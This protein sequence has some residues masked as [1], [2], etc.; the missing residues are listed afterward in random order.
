M[1]AVLLFLFFACANASLLSQQNFEIKKFS[2]AKDVS[3]QVD[4]QYFLHVPENKELA[5][6]ELLPL[7][8]FLHGAGERGSDADLLTVHGPPKLIKAGEDMPFIVIAP[9]CPANQR[10]DAQSLQLF[11]ESMVAQL[12]VDQSRIYL[13]GL[14]M[15]GFGTWD[16]SIAN[17]DYYA[18][19]APICGGSDTNAWDAPRAIKDLPT[20]AFHG[21]MDSVVPLENTSNIIMSLRRAGGNPKYTIYESAGHDS[22]TETYENPELYEWF[23]SHRK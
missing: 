13:T 20:W 15:G 5:E 3:V 18:A 12:P 11:I 7:I 19:I 22:W 4:Y 10:W 21:A 8:V 23:L 17:P 9:Q 14:S 16:V 1:K 2:E 6:D